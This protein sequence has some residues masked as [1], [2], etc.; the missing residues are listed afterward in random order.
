MVLVAQNL[1]NSSAMHDC[2]LK[3]TSSPKEQ[4]EYLPASDDCK[5]RHQAKGK[6][7]CRLVVDTKASEIHSLTFTLTCW[8]LVKMSKTRIKMFL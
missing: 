2:S 5:E 3:V 7:V 4:I 8:N 6:A 1:T